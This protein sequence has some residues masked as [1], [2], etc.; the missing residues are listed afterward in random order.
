MS[1]SQA[2]DRILVPRDVNLPPVHFPHP[3]RLDSTPRR[4]PL[5]G[6]KDILPPPIIDLT[7][8]NSVPPG[9]LTHPTSTKPKPTKPAPNKIS[10]STTKSDIERLLDVSDIHL[11]GEED[12]T[13]P[14]CYSCS[15]IRKKIR[16]F[17]RRDGVTQ[18]AFLRALAKCK[19]G[20]SSGSGSSPISVSSFQMFMRQIG[21][22]AGANS[23]V[24]YTAYVFFEKMRL[25]EGR[26]KTKRREEM[27]R[28]WGGWEDQRT[29]GRGFTDLGRGFLCHVSEVPVMDEYGMMHFLK[30]DNYS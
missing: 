5:P 27:E 28:V 25:R 14:I 4:T 8:E 21:V 30:K 29:G 24:F 22:A 2:L 6:I 1:H 19:P 11:E 23:Q 18:A 17:L 3:E 7:D 10:K 16:A 9:P 13:V 12:G 26:P 15:D 20:G